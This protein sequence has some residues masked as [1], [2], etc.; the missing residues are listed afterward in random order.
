[1]SYSLPANR[2]RNLLTSFTTKKVKSTKKT[3]LGTY[4]AHGP[5]GPRRSV[6]TSTET[7]RRSAA[8]LWILLWISTVKVA[9]GFTNE[10]FHVVVALWK[11]TLQSN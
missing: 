4:L 9:E 1:M 7:N 8:T 5:M 10:T 6:P 2:I 11:Q 3:Y